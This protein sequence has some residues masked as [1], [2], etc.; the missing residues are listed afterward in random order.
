MNNIRFSKVLEGYDLAFSAR[1]L[2]QSTR[3]DYWNT[4]RLFSEFLDSDPFIEEITPE[5]VQRFLGSRT[6]SNKTILNYHTGLSAL[7]Q[8]AKT[9]HLV[10]ENILRGIT[11]P[12]PKKPDIIPFTEQE[13]R[14]LLSTI[15]QS[16]S[17]TVKGTPA[18]HTIPNAERNRAIILT[19]LDTGVR[20]SELCHLKIRN[21]DIRN[22]EKKISVIGGKGDKDRHPP[23]SSRTAQAIWRYL[24]T[25]PD[26]H[27]DDPLFA[28]NSGNPIDRNNLGNILE[29]AGSRAG[30]DDCFPHRFRHTFAIN[31]LRNGGNVY[32][33]QSILGHESLKT[34]LTY[35]K[36]AEA[37][38][39]NAHRQASPVENWRL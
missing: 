27:L 38:S 20:A 1:H 13:I 15:S 21:A 9:D 34:C 4:F 8:W 16:K 29:Y 19:L 3:S 39:D 35:L 14:L 17:Y 12:K 36:I 25:R 6:T 23:I 5:M 30:V 31:F 37:D 10:Q 18:S 33:L 11:R 2:S 7:W 28:T 22:S 32:A 26:A 24:A